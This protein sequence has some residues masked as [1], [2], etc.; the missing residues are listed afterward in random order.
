MSWT[1]TEIELIDYN[2][3]ENRGE[4]MPPIFRR[5]E[6]P[7]NPWLSTRISPLNEHVV[8]TR[9]LSSRLPVMPYMDSQKKRK[10]H[11]P[12]A[13]LFGKNKQKRRKTSGNNQSE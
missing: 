5:A 10:P 11:M 8:R 3:V 12:F 1:D 4:Q 2:E 6:S 13:R 9:E 7:I